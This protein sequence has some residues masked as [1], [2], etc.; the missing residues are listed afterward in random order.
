MLQER[1]HRRVRRLFVYTA[2]A[3]V[4]TAVASVHTA[5][6]SVPAANGTSL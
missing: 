3:S 2:V 5:V 1:A 4:P 6:A